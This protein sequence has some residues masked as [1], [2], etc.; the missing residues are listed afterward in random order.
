MRR[1]LR[2]VVV[3][4]RRFAA[5]RHSIDTLAMAKGW[6]VGTC[7]LTRAPHRVD[8]SYEPRRNALVVPLR[9]TR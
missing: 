8:A 2:H 3:P 1:T 4:R 6:L 9:R 5:A 7:E